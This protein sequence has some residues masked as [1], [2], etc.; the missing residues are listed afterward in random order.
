MRLP[1]SR[2][3]MVGLAVALA[4]AVAGAAYTMTAKA[5]MLV[6]NRSYASQIRLD[7]GVS[8]A[9]KTALGLNLPNNTPSPIPT[10]VTF[11]LV[12]VVSAGPGSHEIR[13]ADS[14]TP[15]ARKKA[16]GA[17]GMQLFRGIGTAPIVDPAL[18]SLL[19][20]LTAQPYLSVFEPGDAGKVATYFARW[21]TRGKQAGGASALV[22]PWSAGVSFGI[23]F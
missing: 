4:V 9:D 1:S 14:T 11:P 5:A 3:L 7:P 16:A 18:C 13:F 12:N 20:V 21:Q 22:G 2:Y 17:I 6:I 15:A 8:N 23:A 19:D 10:P